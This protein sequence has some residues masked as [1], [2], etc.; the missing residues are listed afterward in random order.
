MEENYNVAH[1]VIGREMLA[2]IR[3]LYVT[4]HMD[5]QA[6]IRLLE[7][8]EFK[9]MDACVFIDVADDARSRYQKDSCETPYTIPEDTSPF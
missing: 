3:K 8:Y 4:G 9:P 6:F 1:K 2:T 5:R 7:N